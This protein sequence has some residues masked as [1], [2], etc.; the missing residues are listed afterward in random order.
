VKGVCGL[1]MTQ[2]LPFA[3]PAALDAF[4]SYEKAIYDAL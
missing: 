1:F 2:L 4:R 3:D